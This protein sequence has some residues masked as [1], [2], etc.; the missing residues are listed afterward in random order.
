M[1]YGE[2]ICDVNELFSRLSYLCHQQRL[3]DLAMI[4]VMTLHAVRRMTLHA[5]RRMTLHAVRRMTLHA[6]RRMTLH[7][8][9]RMDLRY[10]L[11]FLA[12]VSLS[13]SQCD[14]TP[15]EG[16][17]TRRVTGISCLEYSYVAI[18]FF[19]CALNCYPQA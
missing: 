16:Q 7:A 11:P 17:M 12:L 4:S 9:R 8:V 18:T 3:T 10:W 15:S 6:V 19:Q 13:S 14:L 2:C 1:F 5:V